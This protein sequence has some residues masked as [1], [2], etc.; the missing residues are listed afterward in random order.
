MH[1]NY[2]AQQQVDELI[3]LLNGDNASW[4]KRELM[5]ALEALLFDKFR[6]SLP[7]SNDELTYFHIEELVLE[8]A[9]AE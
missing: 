2:F 8:S 9:A 4:V 7:L 3:T 6:A 1:L 5:N